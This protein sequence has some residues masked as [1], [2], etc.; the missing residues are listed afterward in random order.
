MAVRNA[1]NWISRLC[2][3][4]QLCQCPSQ[5]GAILY[6]RSSQWSNESQ[7]CICRITYC[8]AGYPGDVFWR[9]IQS[10]PPENKCSNSFHGK[11]AVTPQQAAALS[12]QFLL[13]RDSFT[14]H[15]AICGSQK[16]SF[17]DC[18]IPTQPLQTKAALLLFKLMFSG[19]GTI[20]LTDQGTVDLYK[21]FC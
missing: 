18:H 12:A 6:L 4:G 5:G 20:P 21:T 3:Q 13:L 11:R 17:A 19:F 15:C 10:A 1:L 14:A 8:R 7:D 16:A 2:S 9:T